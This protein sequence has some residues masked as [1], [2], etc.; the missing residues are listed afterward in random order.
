MLTRWKLNSIRFG[1]RLLA[2][3]VMLILIGPL[4]FYLCYVLL[5][6]FNLKAGVLL[7]GI[8]I[9]IAAGCGLLVL[10]LLLLAVE[11]AQDRWL[12][13]HHRRSRNKKV[14]V[15]KGYYECQY[16]GYSNV[17]EF[18]KQCPACGKDLV[19]TVS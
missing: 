17:H 19:E 11:F 10:F 2:L 9:S 3:I 13:D 16:C 5:G 15:S 12:D 6:L 1:P 18:D 4:A 14:L 8:F 7:L